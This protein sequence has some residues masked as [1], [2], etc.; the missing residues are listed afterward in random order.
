MH[1]AKQLS[2]QLPATGCLLLGETACFGKKK[3]WISEKNIWG[4]K[5]A[6]GDGV[7]QSCE[8]AVGHREVQAHSGLC[9]KGEKLSQNCVMAQEIT[10]HVW[11]FPA[12]KA[13]LGI[14]CS[15]GS[16]QPFTF[17]ARLE[18]WSC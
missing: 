8:L 3:R 17:K 6:G 7:E 2:H 11:L 18:R 4:D 5:N 9:V 12:I 14:L 16:S 13:V 15:W 10:S 1:K